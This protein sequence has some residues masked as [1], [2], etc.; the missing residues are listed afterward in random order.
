[1][2]IMIRLRAGRPRNR[3]SI[4]GGSDFSLLHG[5]HTGSVAHPASLSITWRITYVVKTAGA[6]S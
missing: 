5:V 4:P 6:L 3:L 2:S 1:M